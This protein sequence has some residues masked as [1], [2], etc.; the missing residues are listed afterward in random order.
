MNETSKEKLINLFWGILP[1][2]ITAGVV[3]YLSSYD[4]KD[5]TYFSIF[6]LFS[7][8]ILLPFSTAVVCMARAI[9]L[10]K[11]LEIPLNAETSYPQLR[12]L[13]QRAERWMAVTLFNA[14]A[15][16]LIISLI[17][18]NSVKAE[19][20]E[21]PLKI[22][23]VNQPKSLSE[24]SDIN[25]DLNVLDAIVRH[26]WK[27]SL[28][29][30]AIAIILVLVLIILRK[31]PLEKPGPVTKFVMFTAGGMFIAPIVAGF[32]I[33]GIME[34]IVLREVRLFLNNVSPSAEVI[35]QGKSADDGAKIIKGLAK[36]APMPAHRSRDTKKFRIEIIDDEQGL[37]VDLARDSEHRREY[38][39]FYPGYR[40]TSVNEIGRI[41][42]SLFDDY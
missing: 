39:V 26:L 13:S 36:A 28:T 42:T 16:F 4:T 10:A 40:Y 35:L 9:I 31:V 27:I 19:R 22:V 7:A 21:A 12:R 20:K 23:K 11:I 24:G 3:W 18:V 38:W 25:R 15:A 17:A 1:F 14:L 5:I 33:S 29:A 37:V 41:R 6:I 30:I 2:I 34:R 32:M 8:I